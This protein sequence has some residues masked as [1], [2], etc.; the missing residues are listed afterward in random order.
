MDQAW[1]EHPFIALAVQFLGLPGKK[2]RPRIQVGNV[3]R[4][5]VGRF[6]TIP[7]E[8][9]SSAPKSGSLTVRPL[10]SPQ[11][12]DAKFS[13]ALHHSALNAE[14][15]VGGATHALGSQFDSVRR[16][17][18]A[19]KKGEYWPYAAYC[20]SLDP[21][22]QLVKLEKIVDAPGAVVCLHVFQ[23]DFY[24][25]LLKTGEL[26]EW[27]RQSLPEGA[28]YGQGPEQGR[29][30]GRRRHRLKIYLDE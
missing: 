21:I 8:A 29:K 12:H 10:V 19:P 23:M 27:A 6:I 26:E 2:G 1:L 11:Y 24:V 14:A 22:R 25:D 28:Y 4:D 30:P 7:V 17:V 18:R 20:V 3:G 5:E 15:L 9:P 16:Y 13:R